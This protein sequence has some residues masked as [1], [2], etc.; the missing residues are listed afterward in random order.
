MTVY[1]QEIEFDLGDIDDPL[2]YSQAMSSAQASLW[3]KTMEEEL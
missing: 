2:S 1:L 3:K